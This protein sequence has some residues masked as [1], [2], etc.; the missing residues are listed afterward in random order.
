MV[1]HY[2]YDPWLV[3]LSFAMASLASLT[4]LNLAGRLRDTAGLARYAWL[5]GGAFAMG[6]GIWAMHFIGML[7]MH[8]AMPMRY[9]LTITLWSLLASI[10]TSALALALVRKAQLSVVRLLFGGA[11]MGLGIC[12]MH[13]LGMQAMQLE[14][15]ISYRMDLLLLSI[16]VAIVAAS[17]ALWLFFRLNPHGTNK[18]TTLPVRCLAALVMAVAITG[19]HY[20]GMAAADVAMVPAPSSEPAFSS[21]A[22]SVAI[23]TVVASILLLALLMAIYD[24]HLA[25]KNA[26]LAASLKE[27]NHELQSLVTLDVLTRL[28]NRLFLEQRLQEVLGRSE[29]NQ[30]PFSVLF[31]NLDRF[32]TV[33]DS[34]G[35]HIGDT[36]IKRAAQR[37]ADAVRNQDAAARVG[38][39]EFMIVTGEGTCRRGSETLAQRIVSSLGEPFQLGE[40]IVCISCSVGISCYPGHG[41]TPHELMTHADAAMHHAKSLGRNNYQCYEPGLS[42]VAE[43]RNHLERRLRLALV[44]DSLSLAYQP[45]VDVLS[46]EVTGVEALLRWNDEELGQVTPDEIIPVAEETGLILPV[47]EWVLRTAC[48]Q[49]QRWHAKG[50]AMLPVAVNLSAIQLNNQ[51]FVGMVEKILLE[52]QLPAG[53][54]EFELTESAIMQNPDNA[55]RILLRL[56]KL[57]VMLSIDDFGTGYSNLSQLKRFPINRLKIDRSFT[58]GVTSDP[59]DAAIVKAVSMLAHSLDLDIVAEGVETDE[60]LAFIRELKGH[61]YQGYLCSKA[62]PATQLERFLQARV[63]LPA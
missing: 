19:M 8:T 47:G 28:P 2:G 13:Y 3:G 9:D 58:A 56:R 1:E 24:G 55:L 51:H 30:Q 44:N 25:T 42:S 21:V 17:G 38:G 32:K 45:K 46:G 22:F 52:T 41:D 37:L 39:D 14:Q 62:L 50:M 48:Q 53:Y 20:I 12:L 34:L 59:Q 10:L 61:Q 60:Q 4:A 29:R 35:H 6:A 31:V 18:R 40:Q 16:V 11:V 36:L 5:A 7:A 26:L 54:L 33:N 23:A 15:P 43:R 49:V 63:A 27:A 57:G